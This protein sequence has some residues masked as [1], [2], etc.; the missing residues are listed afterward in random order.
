MKSVVTKKSDIQNSSFSHIANAPHRKA[1]NFTIRLSGFLLRFWLRQLVDPALFYVPQRAMRIEPEQ[2]R[3]NCFSTCRKI[4]RPLITP[5]ISLEKWRSGELFAGGGLEFIAFHTKFIFLPLEFNL[6]PTVWENW[7][8]FY[9]CYQQLCC[10][11]HYT[12]CSCLEMGQLQCEEQS[13]KV[14]ICLSCQHMRGH[15]TQSLGKWFNYH[16]QEFTTHKKKSPWG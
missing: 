12:R 13:F 9:Y 11:L 8:C 15:L 7:K 14:K 1:F 2:P 16:F 10:Y 6:W 4:P 5:I 3:T